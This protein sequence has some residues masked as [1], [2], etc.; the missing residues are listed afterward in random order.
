[1]LLSSSDIIIKKTTN[2]VDNIRIKISGLIGGQ[3]N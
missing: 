3:Y 2:I 1:M